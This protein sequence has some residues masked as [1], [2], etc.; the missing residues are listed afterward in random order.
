[1]IL[2]RLVVVDLLPK[3]DALEKL[4]WLSHTG[5]P[6]RIASIQGLRED[7]GSMPHGRIV[8]GRHVDREATRVLLEATLEV[9]MVEAGRGALRIPDA[10]RLRAEHALSLAASTLA[11]LTQRRFDAYSPRPFM[12]LEPISPEDREMLS[13][14]P[15]TI[16]EGQ[17][18]SVS[19]APGVTLSTIAALPTD[20]PQGVAILGAALGSAH[21]MAKLHQLV[22][23]F[24]NC[25]GR[26]GGELIKP[27]HRFLNSYPGHDLQYSKPEVAL[28]VKGLRDASAHADLTKS[29]QV[30]MDPDVEPH[31]VRAEQA[32]YD[33]LFNKKSWLS[34]DATREMRLH[35]PTMSGALPSSIFTTVGTAWISTIS[36]FGSLDHFGA[37]RL[38][39][40]TA[41]DSSTLPAEW[42]AVDWYMPQADGN[43]G[44]LL[45]PP[46]DPGSEA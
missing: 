19:V 44:G 36:M 25:F 9:V 43:G 32:A 46:S 14:G 42:V 30:L 35:F 39:E 40:S 6:V 20:R 1:M 17:Q 16:P 3:L 12:Y 2:H 28:W 26:P 21:G 15:I 41:I 33:V 22:R 24:E 45:T 7:A 31:L 8:T 27:L 38:D 34:K 13:S 5:V 10:E 37:F 4:S 29:Q 23:L 11:I 18:G